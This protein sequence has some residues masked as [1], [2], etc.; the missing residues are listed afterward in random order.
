MVG[1]SPLV[2]L[3]C[4]SIIPKNVMVSLMGSME[5]ATWVQPYLHLGHLSWRNIMGGKQRFS[6][7]WCLLGAAMLLMNFFLGDRDEPKVK[8]SLVAQ[9]KGVYKN[10]KL[11]I[12][13]F[14]YFITFGSFVA[15][16]VYLP[17]FLV[18]HFHLTKVDAG[19]RTGGFIVLATAM[20]PIGGWLADRWNPFRM[21]MYRLC[22]L[23][24]C[25][26]FIVLRPFD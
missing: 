25:R 15:F 23:N 14:F 5:L 10:E 8:T 16:S 24:H 6:F 11:W 13:C 12:L 19:L 4:P 2:S 21:L 7:I 9:I 18:T 1:C 22:R 17:N 20:R 26:D 3:P